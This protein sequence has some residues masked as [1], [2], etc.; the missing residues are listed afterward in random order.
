[1]VTEKEYQEAFGICEKYLQQ[2][3]DK[4]IQFKSVSNLDSWLN[5][6]KGDEIEIQ[7]FYGNRNTKIS[8]GDIF[9]VVRVEVEQHMYDKQRIVIHLEFKRNDSNRIYRFR[10]SINRITQEVD[11][12]YNLAFS[13]LNKP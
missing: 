4:M 11:S 2:I 12:P 3:S 8:S 6:K 5:V 1:M 7:K 9:N 10:C 13:I